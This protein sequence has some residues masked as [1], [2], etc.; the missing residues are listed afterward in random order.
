MPAARLQRPRRAL[1][2]ALVALAAGCASNLDT[3]VTERDPAEPAC[4]GTFVTSSVADL[5]THGVCIP[6]DDVL[7]APAAGRVYTTSE[8]AGHV[9]EVAL[10]SDQLRAI[11][12][13]RTVTVPTS[14]VAGHAHEITIASAPAAA[15]AG[16]GAPGAGP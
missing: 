15:A 4:L 11:G 3:L 7:E 16:S 13:G 10:S 2:A 12:F 6:D 14:E 5:H 1:A 8:A 9:H